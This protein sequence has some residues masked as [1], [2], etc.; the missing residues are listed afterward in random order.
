MMMQL[1][2]QRVSAEEIENLRAR[3]GIDETVGTPEAAALFGYRQQTLR[4]WASDGSGPIRP[5][6]VNGRLRWSVAQIRALLAGAS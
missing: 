1:R 3:T 2:S 6:R 5:R 4:R